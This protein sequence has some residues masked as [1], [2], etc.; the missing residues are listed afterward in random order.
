[1]SKPI[2]FFD[3]DGTLLDEDKNLPKS[4]ELAIE[5]MKKNGIDVVLATGRPPFLFKELRE[6]LGINS[7]I[8]YT[9]QYVVFEGE[10]I[11]ENPLSKRS[12]IQLH[13]DSISRKYPMVLMSST[14]MRATV[15]DHPHVIDGLN[16]LK[17][18]YPEVDLTFHDRQSIFQV[19]L[20]NEKKETTKL[21]ETYD[22]FH[23]IHWG[24]DGFACDVL[25]KG[26]SKA[27]GI[28]K[29]L[30]A[31]GINKENS[32]AFGDGM[33][34]LEMIQAVGT[35]IAMGNAVKPLKDIADDITGSVKENGIKTAL[36]K[37][38]LI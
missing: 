26:G 37:Y 25:P 3:I 28:Q 22:A 12:L 30:D 13:K 9:G 29:I 11:Y 33:N 31:T 35:G 2:V 32:F 18:Q 5:Q 17:F 27:V 21:M 38:G 7:Y 34:D 16:R 23:F 20:F 8:S 15:A 19:L 10:K 6:R 4:T 24:S 14:E 36:K 1:M